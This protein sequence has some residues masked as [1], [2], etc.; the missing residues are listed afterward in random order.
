MAA[1]LN[2]KGCSDF[3]GT[4][5]NHWFKIGQCLCHSLV[6]LLSRNNSKPPFT[7][8]PTT[9]LP[10]LLPEEAGIISY[11]STA[12][13]VDWTTQNFFD[14]DN[15]WNIT[16]P[17]CLKNG[18]YLICY[19]TM[20]IQEANVLGGAQFYTQCAQLWV[21]GGTGT[22]SPKL[23]PLPGMLRRMRVGCTFRRRRVELELYLPVNTS[24]F[25]LT[26]LA[27]LLLLPLCI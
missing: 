16:I 22:L 4:T 18:P 25:A 14:L 5:G 24:V 19:E 2:W 23:V 26:C 9:N 21:E 1:C 10:I 27:E 20:A 11:N 7:F 12:A 8:T 15:T 13:G 6:P 17:A 3:Y